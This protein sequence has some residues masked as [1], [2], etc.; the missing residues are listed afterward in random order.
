MVPSSPC[1]FRTRLSGS[2]RWS[3]PGG[4]RRETG[5]TGQ[6][7]DLLSLWCTGGCMVSP[8]R[9]NMLK[10]TT[11]P[12]STA[13][14]KHLSHACGVQS[15]VRLSK[16]LTLKQNAGCSQ[17]LGIQ[18]PVPANKTMV[19]LRPLQPTDLDVG[20]C[21]PSS[22]RSCSSAQPGATSRRQFPRGSVVVHSSDADLEGLRKM[23]GKPIVATT[24]CTDQEPCKPASACYF[25]EGQINPTFST[26][27]SPGGSMNGRR[28]NYNYVGG[29]ESMDTNGDWTLHTESHV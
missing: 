16:A 23:T 19:F 9:A 24:A 6:D 3:P 1:S 14:L 12:P 10:A 8:G 21:S 17:I 2:D 25:F 5:E 15:A 4:R 29:K 28:N 18:D 13:Q 20:L 22:S 27:L 26:F 11:P 7:D